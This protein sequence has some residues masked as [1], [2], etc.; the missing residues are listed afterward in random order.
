MTTTAKVL[1]YELRDV[2][3]SRAVLVYALFFLAASD[4]LFR[5]SGT[6]AK[7]LLSL[8]NVTLIVVPLVS[9]VLGTMFL[10]NAR[11]F[12]EL[13]L[14]Q[15]VGRRQLYGGLYMGLALPLALGFL[16][17]TALPVLLHG[18]DEPRHFVALAMLCVAGLLL[19]GIFVALAFVVALAIEDRVRGMGIALLVWLFLAV[20]WDGLVMLGANIF[21]AYPL[22]KPLLALMV[23]NPVD[24]ARV[25]LMLNF[26]ISAL[27]GYTGA[28]FRDFFG[29]T[30]G[31]AVALTALG[32]W[33]VVPLL[34][35][36]RLFGRKDF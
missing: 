24:L 1:K 31:L 29:N 27:M 16:A 28:V 10:Y 4:L 21:Y 15:P 3:R 33:L 26:D 11:E 32:S 14:S 20:V 22:E 17:G 35:G 25:T 23:L 13:L 2:A 7:A 9:V 6:S 5:F 34:I 18:V 12:N 30:G 36:F 8:A 19:T